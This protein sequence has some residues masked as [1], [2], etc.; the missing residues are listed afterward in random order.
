MQVGQ[1]QGECEGGGGALFF[2]TVEAFAVEKDEL[3]DDEGVGVDAAESFFF[4]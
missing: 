1:S 4:F 2:F 3:L